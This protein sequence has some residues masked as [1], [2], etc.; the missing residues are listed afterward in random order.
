MNPNMKL[1]L[2]FLR[3]AWEGAHPP[4]TPTPLGWQG[5]PLA[6]HFPLRFFGPDKSLLIVA[7]LKSHFC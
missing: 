6:S 4:P 5:G 3:F 2:S 1:H 7:V